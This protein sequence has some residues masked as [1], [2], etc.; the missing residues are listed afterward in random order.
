[1]TELWRRLERPTDIASLA[2]FRFLIGAVMFVGLGRYV[3]SGWVE[4]VFIEPTYFFKYPGFGWVRVLEPAGLYALF[5]ACALSALLVALG[6]LYR[7][8]IVTFLLS[9]AYVQLMDVTNYLN[10]YYLVVLLALLMSFL[11]LDRA[12]SARTLLRPA[13]RRGTV[14]AWMLY[15]LRLQIALVYVYAA[16]AKVGPDWLLFGQPL[17]I[18]MS[19]R[20]ELPIIG[21]GLALPGV[22]LFM[23]WAGFL[24][25]LSI[26]P[27]LLWKRSRP[28]AYG[29]VLVFHVFT[30]V[31]FDIGMFPFIMTAATTLFFEP[32][33][34][35][36]LLR[37]RIEAKSAD[38]G[39]NAPLTAVSGPV[40]AAYCVFQV[41]VPLRHFFYEGDV[42][43]NERGMRYAWK[44]MVREKNGSVTY[45]VEDPVSGRTWSVSPHHYLDWRQANEMA[46]QPDLIQQLAHHVAADFA[47]RGVPDVR[48]RVD[49]FASLNGRPAARLIDPSVD[50]LRVDPRS[51]DWILP[52]PDAPPVR[53]DF[54]AAQKSR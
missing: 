53:L 43:W 22:A 42:L 32:D 20:S 28:W 15:V 38:P 49:S 23:S 31:F 30:W 18:W 5:G 10:H 40:L 36:R 50:L 11:P 41:L 19:A 51:G 39:V 37:G 52:A 13:D 17:N 34:P 9:F 6:A 45:R 54:H 44:V 35:R 8:A 46:A 29:A 7:V 33:W 26:V 21:P 47:A 1:M 2:A 12:L 4:I 14:P 3:A 48:V 24:Y 25:D 16:L 27:L